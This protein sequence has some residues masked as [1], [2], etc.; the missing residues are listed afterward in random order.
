MHPTILFLAV[1]TVLV[2]SF[3]ANAAD[4][5]AI[6]DAEDALAKL[7]GAAGGRLGVYAVDTGSG[8]QIQLRAN[9]RFPFCSTF[10]FILVSAILDRSACDAGLLEHHVF[11]TQKDLAHYSPI[12]EKHLTNGMTVAGLCAAAIQYSDNTA[13]NQLIKILGG[14]AAVTEFARTTGNSEFRLDRW[15]TEL[16]SAIPGD[17]RD[18]ATPASMARSM[19]GFALGK[20]LQP[21]Q[22]KQLVEWLLGNTTGAK[23]IRAGVPSGWKVGDKTGSGDY[24]TANDVGVVWPP[25]RKPLVIAIYHTQTNADAKWNDEVIASAARIV[26]RAF[27]APR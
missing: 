4:T 13:A 19:E 12:T 8:A 22:Q 23:R 14:P 2:F 27:G 20:S 24:G 1:A 17:P 25:G 16:N 6:A 18:T 26:T 9:E 21:P 3:L 7:E 5:N 11:Y 15:E 10:K